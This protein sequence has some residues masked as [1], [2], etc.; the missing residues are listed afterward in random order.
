MEISVA[1]SDG[2]CDFISAM[3]TARI[4]EW[5]TW[6]HILNCGFPL[7][8]S[9]ETDFPCMSGSRVGQGRVY[10]QLDKNQPL[11]YDA[12]CA[13]L[14]AGRSY[15]SDGFAH[16]VRFEVAGRAPG[17]P[18]VRLAEPGSVEVTASV[19]FAP[20][21]PKTVAQGLSFA[22]SGRRVAGDTVQ[23]H[24][25]RPVRGD[26]WEQ[27]GTRLVELIV[28]G[29]V[30]ATAEI[31]ADGEIH[32]LSWSVPVASSSWIA[33]RQFPQLHTNPVH[34]IV[35]DRPIRASR[36]SARW[37]IETIELLWENRES[38]IAADERDAARAAFE[39]ALTRFRQIER[40]AASR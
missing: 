25:E 17:S 34:V 4:Q 13:G 38:R 14:A 21:M 20:E 7:K 12:W 40:D 11:S 2:V 33:L 6:Y 24:A 3:D 32:E 19:A 29:K 39:R 9:G 8:V 28:N 30:M 10:V 35:G 5:N 31:P 27:G 23:M 15:V 1:V 22:P 36:D 26:E 18:D 16:A 37:C